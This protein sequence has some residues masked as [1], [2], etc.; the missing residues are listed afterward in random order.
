LNAIKY[1]W[2]DATYVYCHG[3]HAVSVFDG[4]R[5]HARPW[6]IDSPPSSRT[7]S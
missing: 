3:N 2:R 6:Q 5:R 1:K 7:L 4:A